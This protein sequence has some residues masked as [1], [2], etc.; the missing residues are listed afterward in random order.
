DGAMTPSVTVVGSGASGVHFALSVLQKGGNV[1]MLDVGRQG[2]LPVL[3]EASLN[4]LKHGL[5]DPS[6]YFL[7]PR[8][9]GVLLPGVNDEYYGIPPSKEFVF[10]QPPGFRHSSTGFSPLFSFARG[11]LAEVWTGG[12]Y[13]FT[14]GEM[15]DF[16]FAHADL[17][18]HYGEVARRI[19]VTG[20]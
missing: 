14:A 13:P 10:G 9:E 7:G 19:G 12:C 18:R 2:R 11:G 5:G 17:V 4:G 20:E 15:S 16:P 3:P 1:R 6:D 8:Y